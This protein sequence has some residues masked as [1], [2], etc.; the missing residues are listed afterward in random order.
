MIEGVV[1]QYREATVDLTVRGPTGHEERLEFVVDTGFD[2]AVLLHSAVAAALELPRLGAER[3]MLADG[4]ET[5]FN[6]SQVQLLWNGTLRLV[7][8]DVADAVSLVGMHVL[9]G[10][11]IYI[12]AIPNGAVQITD[13]SDF[14]SD[15]LPG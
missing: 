9:E 2:G 8:V 13:I 5:L 7:P 10:H 14:L 6:C 4:T 1:N 11:E 12:H 3:A 15:G